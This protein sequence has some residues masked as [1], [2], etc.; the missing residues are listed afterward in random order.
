MFSKIETY[1]VEVIRGQ[2]RGFLIK[3]VLRLFSFFYGAAVFLRNWAYDH[4]CFK[5]FRP[6]VTVISIGNIVAGGT[7]KTPTVMLCAQAFANKYK[8]AVLSRGYRSQAGKI[9]AI[10]ADGRDVQLCGDEP[11]LLKENL[12]EAMVIVGRDRARSALLAKER[13]ADLVILDDGM[14]HRRVARDFEVVVVDGKDPFGQGKFLPAGFLR[15]NGKALGRADL[16]V[17]NH[18]EGTA[19]VK[20]Q[21]SSFSKAPMA[22]TQ[23][24][25][26]VA[27]DLATSEKVHLRGQKVAAFCGIANPKRFVETLEKEGAEVVDILVCPDHKS[28]DPAAL[29]KF[30]EHCRGLG[31]KTLV[32]TEKD[33]V[34]ILDTTLACLPIAWVQ[35]ELTFVDDES[36]KQWDSFVN[37]VVTFL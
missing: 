1:I 8:V 27:F 36:Q 2:R 14:Q 32:C 23:M 37:K 21:L 28:A 11:C 33:K 18:S 5:I 12:T 22:A 13:G 35:A 10:V 3:P 17:V 20:E 30:S 31:A 26:R 9:P 19:E 7:G 16:I 15:E 34:K 25:I 29:K 24:K 4:R 6:P